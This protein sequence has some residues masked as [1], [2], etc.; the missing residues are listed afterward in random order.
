MHPPYSYDILML[1]MLSKQAVKW[2][3]S[4]KTEFSYK[5]KP[6]TFYINLSNI[7]DMWKNPT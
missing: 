6:C 4:K 2:V 7:S 1:A 3:E 5:V